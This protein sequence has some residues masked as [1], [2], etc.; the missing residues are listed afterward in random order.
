MKK[1]YKCG[2][3]KPLIHF[4]QFKS[5]KNEGYYFSYCKD[6]ERKCRK[7]C[8]NHL[9]ILYLKKHPWAKTLN[10]IKT[11]CRGTNHHY[12]KNGIKNFLKIDDVKYLWFRDK[13]YSMKQPSIDRIDTYGDYKLEN[14]RFIE[15]KENL[16]RPQA[17]WATRR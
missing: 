1:C 9:R 8:P 7:P 11:R 13:A 3:E 6:C 15:L 2:K 16:K 17:K 10:R 4:R 12:H 5:G 14:C